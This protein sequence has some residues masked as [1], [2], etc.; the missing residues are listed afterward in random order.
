[1]QKEGLKAPG[2]VTK[3]GW[4]ITIKYSNYYK[5]SVTAVNTHSKSEEAKECLTKAGVEREREREREN[6]YVYIWSAQHFIPLV[7]P[8]ANMD[9]KFQKVRNLHICQNTWKGQ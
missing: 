6:M 9:Q 7:C 4:V 2:K 8:E 1:M 5:N 3:Q